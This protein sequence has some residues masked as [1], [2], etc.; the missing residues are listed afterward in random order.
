VHC[1][2]DGWGIFFFLGGFFFRGACFG[3]GRDGRM[4]DLNLNAGAAW[5]WAW[6]GGARLW[7]IKLGSSFPFPHHQQQRQHSNSVLFFLLF[8]FRN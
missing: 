2:F 3:S 6:M 7:C 5:A 4:G 1:G 8:L